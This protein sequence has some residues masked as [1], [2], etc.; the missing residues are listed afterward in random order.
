MSNNNQVKHEFKT[1]MKQLL[2]LIIHSLYTNPE[3]FLRELVSNSSDALNKVRFLKLTNEV[4]DK[5]SPLEIRINVDKDTQTISIEDTGLGMDEADLI[6]HLGT[7]AKSGTLDFINNL[8]NS[9]SSQKQEL[10]GQFGVGF[11]SVFMVTD[12][13]T[14][15]TRKYNLDSK[16]YRWISKGEDEFIIEECD[17]QSRGTKISFKL[18]DEFKEL[19]EDWKIKNILHKYSNFVEFDLLVNGDKVNKV[20]AIWQ[21]KKDD[22][23]SEEANEFYKFVTKDWQDPE[24]Y[25]HLNIEGTINFKALLYIPSVAPSNMFAQDFDNGLQLYTN[26]VFIQESAKNLLPD[27]LKFIRGVVDTEDLPLNVSREVTQNSQVVAKIK[28]IIT[29]RVLNFLDELAQNDKEKYLKIYKNF[30]SLIKSGVNSD[31]TNKDRIVSLLRFETTKTKENELISLRDYL[32]SNPDLNE[33]YYTTSSSK[34]VALRN[35]NLEL[36]KKKEIEVLILSDPMDIFI[37]PFVNE[38]DGKKLVSIEKAEL[39]LNDNKD[40]EANEVSEAD[41]LALFKSEIGE[42]VED[43]VASK[44]L[45]DSPV[46]LVAGKNAMDSQM[47]R[48]MQMMDKDFIGSKKILEINLNHNIIKNL[49]KLNGIEDKRDK[50]KDT[51]HQLYESALLLDG[52]MKNPNEFIARLYKFVETATN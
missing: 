7:I 18:K 46:T 38:F 22:I 44:R 1:E 6:S 47:E 33:I 20:E 25:L 8:K 45:V 39:E 24:C 2:H 13:V 49:S 29:T 21:K 10:I 9:N 40:N 52:Q 26:R 48:M 43:V 31:F 12:Q 5:D 28:N 17:R 19:A 3:V 11:Y 32:N 4:I 15:E 34:E 41:I 50:V 51:I 27:Y 36:F 37:I 42:N 14:V 23:K 30:G 16:A 35:P